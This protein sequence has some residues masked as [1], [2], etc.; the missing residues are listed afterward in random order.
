[1][2]FSSLIYMVKRAYESKILG[3]FC[4]YQFIYF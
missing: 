3:C 2:I 1:M 4:K